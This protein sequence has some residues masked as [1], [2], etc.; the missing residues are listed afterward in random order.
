MV[1]CLRSMGLLDCSDLRRPGRGRW[2][3]TTYT[4][5]SLESNEA[6]SLASMVRQSCST[7]RLLGAKRIQNRKLWREYGSG[8]L[9][10]SRAWRALLR[11]V[12][13]TSGLAM[14]LRALSGKCAAH[15]RWWRDEREAAFPWHGRDK[16]AG[17]SLTWGST[18]EGRWTQTAEVLRR[19]WWSTSKGSTA[20]LRRAGSTGRRSISRRERRTRSAAG[21]CGW[22]AWR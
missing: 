13:G 1:R 20:G 18:A 10:P 3:Q 7:A 17:A 9:L 16:S 2:M 4:E 8:V 11:G 19:R 6:L 5:L 15:E 22:R 21:T 14:Q 12:L